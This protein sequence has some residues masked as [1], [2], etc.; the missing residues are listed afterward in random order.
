MSSG[1][2]QAHGH[3]R[4]S[5]PSPLDDGDH[6]AVMM[7]QERERRRIGFDLHDGPVQAM[8]AALLQLR[9]LENASGPELHE[10]LEA[11]SRLLSGA[12]GEMYALVECLSGRSLDGDGLR[13][14]LEACVAELAR[15]DGLEVRIDIAG[16]EP[17]MSD[18]LQIAIFRIVQE[19]LSNVRRHA[20]ARRAVVRL[21]LEP[22]EVVCTVE[23][24]GGGFAVGAEAAK[25]GRE[26]F[27]LLGMRERAR[28][29]GG[30]CC[31]VSAPGCGTT[32]GV[33][34]PVWRP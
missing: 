12:L 16:E 14:K 13:A 34:I 18:S 11:V 33:R 26:R 22:A 23:D 30:R 9:L 29:L 32:V 7:L 21:H 24:D 5:L 19:A 10:G 1:V 6:A 2:P 25:G 31:V 4:G 28:L 8:S 27:G 3:G 15:S 20:G 17:A